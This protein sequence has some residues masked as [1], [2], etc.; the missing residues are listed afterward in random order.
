[1]SR[2]VLIAPVAALMSLAACGGVGS[3]VESSIRSNGVG[4]HIL[5]CNVTDNLIAEPIAAS[6]AQARAKVFAAQVC[7][8]GYTVDT[9]KTKGDWGSNRPTR[10]RVEF[11][12]SCTDIDSIK[13]ALDEVST[14]CATI[15]SQAQETE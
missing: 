3:T 12:F 4:D 1:M 2:A 10:L 7:D 15:T 9:F 8:G 13:P 5:I 11:K 14:I 6:V